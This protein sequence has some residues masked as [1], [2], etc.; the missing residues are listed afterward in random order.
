MFSVAIS[1][2]PASPS[3][4][5][6]GAQQFTSNSD[7]IYQYCGKLVGD[8]RN[9]IEL[10][11]VYCTGRHSQHECHGNAATSRVITNPIWWEVRPLGQLVNLLKLASS[12]R[13]TNY[14]RKKA[15][16]SRLLQFM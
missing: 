11:P 3:V 10:G 4:A 9:H 16:Q 2:S 6:A 13:Y 14:K 12:G 8:R 15:A 7:W 5:S 1:I